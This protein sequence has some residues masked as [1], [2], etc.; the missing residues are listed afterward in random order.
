M[1]KKPFKANCSSLYEFL[2]GKGVP[3]RCCD[4]AECI[5]GNF[6]GNAFLQLTH[7]FPILE[8]VEQSVRSHAKHNCSWNDIEYKHGSS[9][10]GADCHHCSCNMGVSVC[11]QVDNCPL[12]L[13]C[14]PS[15]NVTLDRLEPHQCCRKCKGRLHRGTL[16]QEGNP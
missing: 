8:D 1:C 2:P 5:K 11:G 9:W 15:G 7:F 3:G 16:G 13:G 10:Y 14:S 4:Q 12:P 6:A